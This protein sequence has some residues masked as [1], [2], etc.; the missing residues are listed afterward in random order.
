M[1]IPNYHSEAL[2]GKD[3]DPD[4]WSYMCSVE[5]D[6]Q[7]VMVYNIT[8]AKKICD[9][10]PVKMECLKEG[11]QEENLKTH[12]GEG[13]IWGGLLVSERALMLRLSPHSKIVRQENILRKEIKRQSASI[14][15]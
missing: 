4:L 10:C 3:Y 12:Q 2:C 13:L 11:L 5:R 8:V 6:K 9:M 15:Q 7:R 14:G 1:A